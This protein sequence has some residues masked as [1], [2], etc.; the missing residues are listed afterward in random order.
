MDVSVDSEDKSVVRYIKDAIGE[1]EVLSKLLENQLSDFQIII[2]SPTDYSGGSVL[3]NH[4]YKQM[5]ISGLLI[6]LR[7]D[8]S[9]WDSSESGFEKYIFNDWEIKY[10]LPL[11][12][13]SMIFRKQKIRL[14]IEGLD[15]IASHGRYVTE[16]G[17]N[18]KECVHAIN[19]FRKKY[20]INCVWVVRPTN[21]ITQTIKEAEDEMGRKLATIRILSLSAKYIKNEIIK[22]KERSKKVIWDDIEKCMKKNTFVREVLKHY[23]YGEMFTKIKDLSEFIPKVENIKTAL[24]LRSLIVS[25]YMND[26][27]GNNTKHLKHLNWVGQWMWQ[28]RSTELCVSQINSFYLKQK[29]LKLLLFSSIGGAMVGFIIWAAGLLVGNGA[30][31]I[32]LGLIAGLTAFVLS[33]LYV[34][35][36]ELKLATWTRKKNIST[37]RKFTRQL[38]NG[39]AVGMLFGLLVYGIARVVGVFPDGLFTGV[40]RAVMGS[41]TGALVGGLLIVIADKLKLKRFIKKGV[42]Y[43]IS[44]LAFVSRMITIEYLQWGYGIVFGI[45]TL[46]LVL[47][48]LYISTFIPSISYGIAISVLWYYYRYWMRSRWYHDLVCR[49]CFYVEGGLPLRH[50][51]ALRELAKKGL[52]FKEGK[53][54]RFTHHKYMEY[55]TMLYFRGL[56]KKN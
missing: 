48:T 34:R 51:K 30:A 38:A 46:G 3:T 24:Q 20:N 16:E 44:K 23:F 6:P 29:E 55:F 18:E 17:I 14:L 43:I 21:P 8:V 13:S 15:R 11:Y 27:L 9:W 45:F 31:G 42:E 19:T 40:A 25:Q 32:I 33:A 36:T 39:W 5:I 52:L 53:L 12:A 41:L 1:N 4:L 7:I 2:S 47:N 28:T 22:G 54:W 10:G 37:C 35:T 26:T 49:F 50:E 56:K